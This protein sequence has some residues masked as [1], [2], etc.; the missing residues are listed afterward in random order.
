MASVYQIVT[1]RIIEK[2]EQ[3]VIPWRKPWSSEGVARNWV[4]QKPYRGI[5]QLLLSDGEYLTFKQVQEA[6]G[7]VKKGAKSEIVVFWK[8]LEKETEE[9]DKETIP[10]LRYYRVFSIRDCE[11]I[12]SKVIPVDPKEHDPIEQAEEVLS[13]Y[14]DKPTIS[15][16]DS[17]AYYSPD[18]DLVNVPKMTLFDKAEEYYSTLFHELVHSTGHKSRL[19]RKEMQ[20]DASFGSESYSREELVAE[21]GSAMIC[22]MT[23]IDHVTLD[24]SASYLDSWIRALK[25]DSRL[26]IGASSQAQKAVEYILGES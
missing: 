21:V 5:N 10:L 9:G 14:K 8:M 16:N 26:I 17:S 1:D 11:G 3:G 23:G 12:E 20:G 24:N 22:T 18:M 2:L 15:H 25:G 4:T 7:K 6:G 19:N 13:K